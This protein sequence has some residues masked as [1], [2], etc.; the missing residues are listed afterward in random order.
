MMVKQS[1]L[2]IGAGAAGLMAAKELSQHFDVS[3]LEANSRIGGRIH[4]ITMQEDIVEGGAEFIHGNLPVTLQLLKDAGIKYTATAG[5]MY[6]KKNNKLIVESEMMEGWDAVIQKMKSVKK[7]ITLHQFLQKHYAGAEHERL[8]K[9]VI[10]YAE[11]FDLADINTVSVRYL[12]KEWSGEDEDNFRI[13]TG[14]NSLLAYLSDNAVAN[15]CKLLLN[16]NIR[17]ITWK[18]HD[19]TVYTDTGESFYTNKIL[20]TVPL[21]LL[22]KNEAGSFI[23]FDPPINAYGIAAQQIGIGGVIK[24]VIK[25]KEIFW[26]EDANFFFSDE[27]F[28]PTWWTQLPNNIPILTGWMGGTGATIL[29]TKNNTI[30]LEEAMLSLA[31]IFDK[32]VAEI[33]AKI[34]YTKVFN[35]SAD[36]VSAGAY[37][38]DTPQSKAA[39]ELLTTPLFKTIFFGGEALYKGAHPGTVEAALISGQQA[40][41]QIK[42][43]VS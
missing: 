28:F 15:G 12:Y 38:Y 7:D 32:P 39:R 36:S 37:S 25:F 34:V 19:C 29:S 14:Y 43:A 11:G 8:R 40:A 17:Q 31:A 26:K 35:W 20:I 2:I 22:Y 42:N 18:Q 5:E 13:P 3:V 16:K 30:I 10:A 4:T 21:S 24:V 9:Q 1:V 6:R 33:R 41:I 27:K 23:K